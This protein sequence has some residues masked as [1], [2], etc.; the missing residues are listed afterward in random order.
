MIRNA[1]GSNNL[2]N[3]AKTGMFGKHIKKKV[4]YWLVNNENLDAISF[5]YPFLWQSKQQSWDKKQ[6]F[7]VLAKQKKHIR[8]LSTVS[9]T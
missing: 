8:N 5:M 3:I 4:H 2:F 6:R 1:V 9:F 7:L